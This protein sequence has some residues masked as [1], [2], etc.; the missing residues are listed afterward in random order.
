[1]DVKF[2]PCRSYTCEQCLKA[3]KVGKRFF[4]IH[5]L[6]TCPKKQKRHKAVSARV[7]IDFVCKSEKEPSYC[8]YCLG[9]K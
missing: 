4:S 2:K 9:K 6:Y 3:N 7:C 1:M 5:N 8:E